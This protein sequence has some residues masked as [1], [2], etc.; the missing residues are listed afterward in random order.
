MKDVCDVGQRMRLNVNTAPS[1]QV[2]TETLKKLI[3]VGTKVTE[4]AVA[5]ACCHKSQ[6][7]IKV[8]TGKSLP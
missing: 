1:L 2:T 3:P 7:Q 5:H 8:L 6:H 4:S